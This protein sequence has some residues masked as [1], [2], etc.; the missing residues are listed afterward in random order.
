[1]APLAP[2]EVVARNTATTST[3]KIHDDEVARQYGFAGGL[4]PGVDVYAYLTQ[5]PAAA[6][7]RAWLE[8]GTMQARFLSPVYE[9]DQVEVAPGAT[10]TNE[11]G[12]IV[13]LLG[14]DRGGR[15]CATAEARVPQTAAIAPNPAGWP[16]VDPA[17]ERP[18]ASPRSL[19]PTTPL[20]IVPRAFHADRASE[21]LD[22][23]GD[24]LPL[25]RDEGIAH[26]G[27]LLRLANEVL[28]ANVVLGPWIH[29]GS[30]VQHHSLVTDGDVITARA[31]VSAE[32]EHKGH[33]FVRLDVIVVT[34]DGRV[35]AHIDHTAIYEP[36]RHDG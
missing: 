31:L 34:P 23:V 21:Y 1:M 11:F 5:V 19:A 20:A 14:L 2:Y 25:Y 16:L 32:W 22:E 36:R 6:W 7:G 17:E 24:R 28:G 4:V 35:V 30:H 12:T 26:P 15:R 3:N 29:V 33:R 27:W 9:G 18:P 8:T 13:S 10:L